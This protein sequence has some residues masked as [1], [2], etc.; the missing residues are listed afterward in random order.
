MIKLVVHA[1]YSLTGMSIPASLK[2]G[3]KA[4]RMRYTV[5]FSNASHSAPGMVVSPD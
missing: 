2:Q 4:I 3:K 5:S 1:D